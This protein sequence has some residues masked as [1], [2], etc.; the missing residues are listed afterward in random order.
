VPT[1]LAWNSVL[2]HEPVFAWHL[3]K[4]DGCST[5]NDIPSAKDLDEL[6]DGYN[7]LASATAQASFLWQVSGPIYQDD[8]F[9]E[10]AVENYHEIVQVLSE[11]EL[12]RP[13][14]PDRPHVAHAHA[15]VHC[16]VQR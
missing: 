14:L 15:F 6:L 7:I 11:G 4:H 1:G 10:K 3:L 5:L 8:G 16:K 12:P 9:L 2:P 13:H